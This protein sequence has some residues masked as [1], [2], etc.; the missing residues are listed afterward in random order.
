MTEP[1][2]ESR[3]GQLLLEIQ[4][5]GDH[6]SAQLLSLLYDEL[7]MMAG[8]RLSKEPTGITLQATALVHEAYIK[9]LANR[10]QNWK[11]RSHFLAHASEAM[12]RILVDAARRRKRVKRGGEFQRVDYDLDHVK[13]QEKSSK[14]LA[15]NDA[16][17]KLEAEDEI[18]A[19]LVKLRFFGGF[20][21]AE[22]AKLLEISKPTAERYWAFA[23]AWLQEEM[24]DPNLSEPEEGNPETGK[25][26]TG[27]PEV[28]KKIF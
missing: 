25:P 9:L 17:D 11:N 19:R 27:K 8:S 20:T 1:E 5:G 14:L 4:Q 18:K 26:E 16:L 13:V 21:V 7:K 15:L 3:T 23:R 10:E 28:G 6:A 12:R 24:E 22:S 2:P